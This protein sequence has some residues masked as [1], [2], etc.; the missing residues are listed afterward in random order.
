MVTEAKPLRKL[1]ERARPLTGVSSS[2]IRMPAANARGLAATGSVLAVTGI[3]LGLMRYVIPAADEFSAYPHPWWKYLV[4]MHV[5]ATPAF[6]F[7]AGSIWWRHVVRHWKNRERRASGAAVVT[8]MAI[9]AASGYLLYFVG[10]ETV[11]NITRATH[12]AGG[13]A[14]T[15]VYC[16]HAVM[17]WRAVRNSR[18]RP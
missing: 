5:L 6:F 11:V 8:F 9:V 1:D 17:G 3:V 18:K 15:L 13:I 4:M 16:H 10:A 12:T 2:T 14:V 7:F